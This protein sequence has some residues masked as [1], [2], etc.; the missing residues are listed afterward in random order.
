MLTMQRDRG[1]VVI[2]GYKLGKGVLWWIFAGVLVVLMH[3]GLEDR[4]LGVADHLRHHAHVWSLK[5]AEL[6]VRASTR[7]GLWT[8]TVALIADGTVSL[9][10][11][12]ALLHGHWW[13]PWLVV[14]ATG[15]LLPLE[16]V[17]FVH[18]PHPVRAFVFLANL[19][20]VVYLA[21]TAM[22]ELRVRRHERRDRGSAA[23]L[24]A[25]SPPA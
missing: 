20:I 5:L 15:S 23:S 1:L 9:V 10:E 13:G 8:I 25:G 14:V 6:V 16:V 19:A 11:G 3:L 24:R 17:S 2:I 12:W 18:H 22:R 4:M 7:R 21:R